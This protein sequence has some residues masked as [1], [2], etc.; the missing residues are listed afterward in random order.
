MRP[1][2]KAIGSRAAITVKVARIVGPPTSS[3]AIGMI[4][5]IDLFG[6]QMP[7]DVLD[8]HDS[9][10]DQDADRRRSARTARPD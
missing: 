2:T 4:S 8:D 7:V 6:R 5:V 1:D 10:I 3:T 9:I